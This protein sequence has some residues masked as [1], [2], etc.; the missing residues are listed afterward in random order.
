MQLFLTGADTFNGNQKDATKSLGGFQSSVPVPNS[1]INFLFN[2]ISQYTLEKKIPEYV[3]IILRNNSGAVKTNVTL[4]YIYDYLYKT[5][6]HV[7]KFELAA[8]SLISNERMEKISSRYDGPF[9]GT[10]Y[11]AK[12]RR[13][14][15]IMTALTVGN[16]GEV[17]TVFGVACPALTLA[18][19]ENIVDKIV[20][21]FI[22]NPAIKAVKKSTTEVYFQQIDVSVINTAPAFSTTGIATVSFD[23]NLTNEY[24]EEVLLSASLAIDAG[25]GLWFK[26]SIE[27]VVYKTDAEL[28][29]DYLANTIPVTTENLEVIISWD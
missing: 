27:E 29:A 8:V 23:T 1:R 25:I 28:Y 21:G 18:T 4:K 17:I 15:C 24:D 6:N 13:A 3:G 5:P 2:D 20:E 11:E 22:G 26:R 12:F 19:I 16:I 10:F 14:D 7:C 9:T